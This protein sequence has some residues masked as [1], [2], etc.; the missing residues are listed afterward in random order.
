MSIH[1][2]KEISKLKKS[3]L[4][5]CAAVEENVRKAVDSV[6]K[7]DINE[8]N[9]VKKLDEDIDRMEVDIEEECLKILALHQPV[10]GDLRYVIACLKLNN[11][12]ERI[13]DLA[14]NIARNTIAIAEFG[15]K[16]NELL[17][18]SEMMQ[19]TRAM[20]KKTLDALIE[21][22][23]YLA[24]EVITADDEID[25]LNRQMH[26]QVN[27]WIQKNPGRA[28]YYM[29]LLNVS[30]HLERI[31][32]YATNIAEDVIYLVTGKIIRHQL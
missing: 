8:A 17:D 13:G 24:N 14:T 7:K 12:L 21:M 16:D 20:L 32:D 29:R 30:K 31:A 26:Q 25:A 5:Q 3:I 28:E 22:D 11:D 19:K 1:L 10:A 18:F 6:S 4:Q 2:T 9:E 15:D 27:N 23:I